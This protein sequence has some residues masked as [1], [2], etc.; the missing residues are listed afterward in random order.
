MDGSA[1]SRVQRGAVSV[2]VETPAGLLPAAIR[3]SGYIH[4]LVVIRP[5]AS[6]SLSLLQP[7]PCNPWCRGGGSWPGLYELGVGG[8]VGRGWVK[9]KE[10]SPG[11]SSTNIFS[12]S[13]E[14]LL[15][16]KPVRDRRKSARSI[17]ESWYRCSNSFLSSS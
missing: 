7:N 4:R 16:P 2:V 10:A 5:R 8:A 1:V 15:S 13:S 9:R 12:I 17:Y 6:K 11:P 3:H 14:R